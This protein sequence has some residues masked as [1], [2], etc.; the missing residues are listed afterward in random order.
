[1]FIPLSIRSKSE[2]AAQIDRGMNTERV[3]LTVWQWINEVREWISTRVIEIT[4]FAKKLLWECM[5][6]LY[7]R[8]ETVKFEFAKSHSGQIQSA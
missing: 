1:M 2:R 6:P 5:A 7:T 8:I 3:I 4:A